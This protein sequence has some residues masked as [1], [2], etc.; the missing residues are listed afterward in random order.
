MNIENIL[1]EGIGILQKNKISNPQLDSEILLSN[2][3]KRDKKHIIL[4]PKE[5]LNSE[6]LR[7]FKNLIE[8][9]KKGEPIAYL[10]NKKE[11]WKDEFFVNKDV[12]I[13]RPDSELII[14]QVL[15]IYSKDDQLQILDIGTGSGCILL[16]ILK[17]RSNFYGT[18]IDISKKSINVSKFNA[19][20]LNLTNRVKFFHSSVDNFNNGKYDIIVSNPPY[21]E[22]LSL[23]YLEKDVVNFE[24]KL[25]L[26][27]GFDGFS[28]IRKVINKASIL[29][30]K[31][32]KFILEIGFNQKNKVIKILKEEGFYVNKAIKDYGN[33]DRCIISTKI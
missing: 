32:G 22:Q 8:R 4:N 33:N 7:K 29:I 13:P 14:E 2:S 10:I 21:I 18:G 12:L 19:K 1:K 30:K 27:G 11:F 9:R 5:V 24:P 15:K 23:K 3:I 6:Q 20:Q 16:S 26:S 25:A 28:K 31:N 17:E